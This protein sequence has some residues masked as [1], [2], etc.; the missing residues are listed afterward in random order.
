MQDLTGQNFGGY[1]L[2][3]KLGQGGMGAVYKARQPLLNRLVALK[4]MA[5]HLAA[6]QSFVARFLHEAA[7]AANLS[8]PNLV[9]VF[10][11]GES[12]GCYF[13]AMEFVD[14]ESLGRRLA[15]KGAMDPREAL[16]VIVYATQALAYAWQKTR[17]IHRDIKPDN[18]F[19][20][21]AGEVKLGDLGLAKNLGENSL[22]LTQ[23]GLMMGSPHYISPEQ[24]RAVK[25]LDFRADIYSLGC[26]FF[27][28]LTGRPPYD[29]DNALNV[30]LQHINEPT[31]D[32]FQHCPA[33]PE[34]LGRLVLRMMAKKRE[35]RAQSYEE[36][37]AEL[38]RIHEALK[39]PGSGGAISPP[40]TVAQPAP[41]PPPHRQT[42]VT[43][44][45]GATLLVAVA[46]VLLWAPWNKL[47]E[48]DAA[49]ATNE[50]LPA[51]A[52]T[53]LAALAKLPEPAEEPPPA[54]AGP[55]QQLR[56][57][58]TQLKERNPDFT[59]WEKHTIENGQV[60][61]LKISASGIRDLT[62]IAHL[63][64]LQVFAC[65]GETGSALEDL[66]PLAGLQLTV[67][68]I[69]DTGVTNL[70]PLRGMPL[71]ELDCSNTRVP[72]LAPLKELPLEI[73]RCSHI[74]ITDLAALQGKPLIEL[75]CDHTGVR[76][77]TPLQGMPLRTLRVEEEQLRSSPANLETLRGLAQL[78]SLNRR[79]A[80][81]FFKQFG[82]AEPSRP[83]PARRE[84]S[85]AN[86]L[87][88]SF[89]PLRRPLPFINGELRESMVLCY[90]FDQAEPQDMVSDQGDFQNHGRVENAVW[91]QQGQRG[92]GYQFPGSNSSI[93]VP[94]SAVF[95][96]KHLSLAVWIKTT[97][98]DANPHLICDKQENG[99]FLLTLCGE[100][101]GR[102]KVG[103][104]I[105][106]HLIASDASIADGQ[107][108]HVV[109]AYDGTSQRLYVD[110]KQ[111]RQRDLWSG[112]VGGN[113][114]DL[115]IGAA[116]TPAEPGAPN[117][118]APFVGVLDE[119]ML[120]S[121]GLRPEEIQSLSGTR[122]G[123]AASST[124]VNPRE[125][126]LGLYLHFG[127]NTFTGPRNQSFVSP[128][129]SKFAPKQVNAPQWA[130]AARRLG[131]R[132]AILTAKHESG[133][134]LWDCE[135]YDYDVAA[136]PAKGDVVAEFIA[137]CRAEN[138]LAGLHY[139]IPDAHNEGR[140]QTSGPVGA[141]Y[142]A[143]IKRQLND[144][145]AKHREVD[146]L[147][148]DMARRLSP[149]QWSE[150]ATG[151]NA[152]APACLVLKGEGKDYERDT[153]NAEW[154]WT[155]NA[156][157]N[158]VEKLAAR[159]AKAQADN[160]LF[161]INVGVGPDGNIPENYLAALNRLA[162]LLN[163]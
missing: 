146:V 116:P 52:A 29:G 98:A 163:R 139:S 63:T 24:A 86:T 30:I 80:A 6:D 2:L 140:A 46:G 157:L 103:F 21:S 18:I 148:L 113:Q 20:S 141:T 94:H 62:P 82:P 78:Q 144:L 71:R 128:P 124:P 112:E 123:P 142:F 153:L 159:Y 150:L 149:A 79:P 39:H 57:V 3:A 28:M 32:V 118:S 130:Q 60:A 121:R 70:L 50:I 34:Q 41:L 90:V 126:R 134:C 97:Q 53:N 135:G 143:L 35:D 106:Q 84:L 23:S 75:W 129:A 26:T 77:L 99:G 102:G 160:R 33:C 13:I 92:G 43:I 66:G 125:L 120:F 114:R 69:H 40:V 117:F 61:S 37:L 101:Q 11:A 31:P 127:L 122:G 74:A 76:D 133:F 81:D 64:N 145:L 158:S 9:Q 73:L 154:F 87:P 161:L 8:H 138:I 100:A 47:A 12:A 67:L 19:L 108:H 119:F 49:L 58:L 17:L 59:G 155:Q 88:E 44:A 27:K 95:S 55:E 7:A 111:Q 147:V 152:L 10:T 151:V 38:V 48:Q 65:S 93:R 96:A 105:N 54:V 85:G 36:L 137:A 68:D 110:G 115:V 4:V 45:L 5:P 22:E 14:G 56:Q 156:R 109:G 51:P 89:R 162:G 72:D 42:L 25:D 91:T 107:W 1:E 83:G 104:G 136:S 132:V 15:R 16:A 131:A